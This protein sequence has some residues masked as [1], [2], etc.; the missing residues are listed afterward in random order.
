MDANVEQETLIEHWLNQI[1]LDFHFPK[2]ENDSIKAFFMN[3]IEETLVTSE[4]VNLFNEFSKS[5][6]FSGSFM[7]GA[8]FIRN[9]NP[10]L[11]RNFFEV[12]YDIM[13]PI[14]KVLKNKSK[15]V[16]VDL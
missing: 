16:I 7:E 4:S 9:I 3:M 10:N 11:P 12:E 6:L 1:N 15:D 8:A 2:F 14:A 13:F 5:F